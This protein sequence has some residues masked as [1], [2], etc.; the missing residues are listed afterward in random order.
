MKVAYVIRNTEIFD[1]RRV[2]EILKSK[3]IS[4]GWT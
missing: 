4:I 2:S 1:N 3:L